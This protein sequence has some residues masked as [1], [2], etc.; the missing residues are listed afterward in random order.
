MVPSPKSASAGK[1]VAE[2]SEFDVVPRKAAIEIAINIRPVIL[3]SDMGL[4]LEIDGRKRSA[5]SAS[6]WDSH[7]PIRGFPLSGN[8][9]NSSFTPRGST[10]WRNVEFDCPIRAAISP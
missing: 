10:F 7:H 1:K 2:G 3:G 8:P 4:I 6:R 5:R 9:P